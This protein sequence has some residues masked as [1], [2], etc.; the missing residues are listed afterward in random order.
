MNDSLPSS[1]ISVDILRQAIMKEY[2]QVAQSPH[3]GYHFHTGREAADRIGYDPTLY[4]ALPEENIASFA[5]TGNP[6]CLGPVNAG[7]TVVDV[8]SGAGFDAL[9]ASRMVGPHGK[10]IGIDMT[11][12]MLQ[13]A[14]N[15]AERMGAT[16]VEFRQGFADDLPL[17]ENFSD[18]L[19]SNGVLNLTPD[20]KKTLSEWA[21]VIKPGGR[22]MIGDI[23]ISK[24]MPR[25]ALDNISLWTG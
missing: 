18:V 7:E 17:P 23:M 19:I 1:N 20:K 8:G 13:K 5:G 9:I 14:R 6:F 2:T 12:E 25:E 16:H 24:P 15:G 10:V 4:A 3:K 21:R 11:A 22:L